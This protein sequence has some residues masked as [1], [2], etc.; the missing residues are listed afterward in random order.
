[1]KWI[2][3]EWTKSPNRDVFVRRIALSNLD[4]ALPQGGWL[5]PDTIEISGTLWR[6]LRSRERCKLKNKL[7]RTRKQT[8]RK[9][10]LVERLKGTIT[11]FPSI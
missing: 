3:E 8:I 5:Y 1:M 6:Q 9:A 11:D 10:L 7:S 4:R 2:I